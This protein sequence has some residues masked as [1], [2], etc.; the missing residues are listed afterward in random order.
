MPRLA[1]RSPQHLLRA[2]LCA[3]LVCSAAGAERRYTAVP[4]YDDYPSYYYYDD[5]QIQVFD[6]KVFDSVG[7]SRPQYDNQGRSIDYN[8]G[9]SLRQRNQW[10]HQCEYLKKTD[11]YEKFKK[12]FQDKVAASEAAD[13]PYGR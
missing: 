4:S 1:H 5:D 7:K 9:Y 12:C 13:D 3:G 10:I 6:D 8:V 11:G 2:L